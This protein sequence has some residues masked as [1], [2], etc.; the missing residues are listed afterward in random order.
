MSKRASFI[1][2]ETSCLSEQELLDYLNGR[3][4]RE[5]MHSVESHISDC[6]FCND[7]LEGLAEVKN[8]RQIPLIIRQIHS[9][10]RHEL[11]SHQSRTRKTKMYAW[12]SALVFIILLILLI[13]FMAIH[14][15][16]KHSNTAK[17]RMP[18]PPQTE[19]NN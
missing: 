12:L 8:K 16:L 10:L 17:T 18:P 13:A 11:Q 4:D 9:Q 5:K 6:E 2:E 1:F 3:L 19:K 7:A 15:S 14:L